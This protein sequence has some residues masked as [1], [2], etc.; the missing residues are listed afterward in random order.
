MKKTISFLAILLGLAGQYSYAYQFSSVAPSGQTLY[1]DIWW[2]GAHVTYQTLEWD[3]PSYYS[4][5]SGD[6]IIPDSVQNNGTWYTV[7]AID[8][9]CFRGCTALTSVT[10]P[11]SMKL[12]G[13]DA[14]ANC[15]GLITINYN[16]DSCSLGW[17]GW[18]GAYPCGIFEG[19]TNVTTI[20]IGNDVRYVP[21]FLFY[22]CTGLQTMTVG[23]GVQ[24][25]NRDALPYTPT[26]FTTLNFNATQC[27]F[28]S[29]NDGH[30]HTYSVWTDNGYEEQRYYKELS[31][32]QDCN[33]LVNVNIGMDVTVLARYFFDG[34][35]ALTSVTIPSGITEMY[36][37][38]YYCQHLTTIHCL[39]EY[40][41]ICDDDT[42]EGVPA[43]ADIIAPCGAAYRYQQ[44]DYWMNFSRI[45]ED[46]D[47]ID[48]AEVDGIRV[49]TENGQIKVEGADG[50]ILHVFDM[51][52]RQIANNN[53]PTGVYLVK[54]GNNP[55]RKV[56]VIR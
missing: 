11:T 24:Y 34:C 12:I 33:A 53:I 16:A 43:Y 8:S 56:V 36:G 27:H 51:E 29:S 37:T 9:G 49:W 22:D 31:P 19:C 17:G 1:Y 46:C 32:F 3:V 6:L 10:I 13:Y 35:Q 54:I 52:G 55:A 39:A 42:F 15:I 2:D 40:P 23:R 25:F 5:L 30:G 45:T 41:P 20:N 4:D 28:Y 18:D 50:L 7:V 14:F 21:A 44:S 48:D 47:G 38:F 26:N